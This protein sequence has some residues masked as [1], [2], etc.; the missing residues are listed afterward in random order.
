MMSPTGWAANS[1]PSSPLQ[2]PLRQE[3]P[4]PHPL[5]FPSVLESHPVR[6]FLS[7]EYGRL[8]ARGPSQSIS[9]D[10][11]KSSSQSRE[12]WSY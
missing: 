8:N 12:P 4:A 1:W 5:S 10:F 6:H 11:E 9:V 2:A 7:I 3:S